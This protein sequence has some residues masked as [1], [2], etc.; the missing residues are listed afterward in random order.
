MNTTKAGG[1]FPYNCSDF[2]E[3]DIHPSLGPSLEPLENFDIYIA[4]I[5]LLLTFVNFG[6]ALFPEYSLCSKKS[7]LKPIEYECHDGLQV[8]IPVEDGKHIRYVSKILDDSE[9]LTLADKIAQMSSIRSSSPDAT[10]ST[11]KRILAFDQK[12]RA[13]CLPSG[14]CPAVGP[15]YPNFV[16]PSGS[17]ITGSV[18]SSEVRFRMDYGRSCVER[19]PNMSAWGM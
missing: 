13:K 9:F 2:L 5:L 16:C 4:I 8:E 10:E 7:D 6:C 18:T 15:Q 17:I 14:A 12:K 11:L 3:V 1:M 19:A